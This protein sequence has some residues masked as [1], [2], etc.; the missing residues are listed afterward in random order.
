[1]R[2][3]SL[4]LR[5]WLPPRW[6]LVGGL[7]AVAHPL[8]L[9]W[10]QNYWGGA[11]AAAGGALL[12]GA[13]P[14]L[15]RR[16][17]ALLLAI[18]A[19]G[20]AILANTRPFEGLVLALL[21]GVPLAYHHRRRPV[22]LLRRSVRGL[23][24]LI[25]AA[26]GMMYYNHR[27]TSHA[28][29]L[30]YMVY[31][32]Q[33]AAAPLFVW[34]SAPPAKE[35]R[36]PAVGNFELNYEQ[37]HWRKE[38]SLGGWFIEAVRVKI[39]EVAGDYLRPALAL[40]FLLAPWLGR[41]RRRVRRAALILALF[42]LASTQANWLFAHYVAPGTALCLYLVTVGLRSLWR[43][44]MGTLPAGRLVV[45]LVLVGQVAGAGWWI[46]GRREALAGSWTV[47]RMGLEARMRESGGRHVVFV[48]YGPEHLFH[49]EWVYNT[50]DIDAQDV[51]WV[52]DLGDAENRRLMAYYRDRSP[53]LL[54][55]DAGQADLWP[56]FDV[57][58]R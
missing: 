18:V 52:R 48:R 22:E 49:T 10:G 37:K 2:G 11:L 5:A 23:A 36:S 19:V 13:F 24:V 57:I 25:V 1:M 53:W 50:D 26:G 16:P 31:E 12:I 47:H 34:Q 8:L 41:R 20:L 4:A 7:L 44:R 42:L 54:Y 21:L 39:P 40:P 51:V 58:A 56:Y 45:A 55:D 33:Y 38:L 29:R 43:W 30:P 32:S 3:N 35:Y 15:W 27:V 6:A 28:F 17:R 46:S 14:R 9:Q